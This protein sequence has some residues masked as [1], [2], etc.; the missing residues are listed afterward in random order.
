MLPTTL[1]LVAFSALAPLPL[2][3]APPQGP[4]NSQESRADAERPFL[5]YDYLE[6]GVLKGGQIVVIPGSPLL[7]QVGEL[8]PPTEAPSTTILSNGPP[9]NR[10]DIVLVGDGYRTQD[11]ATYASHCSSLVNN[12][13]LQPPLSN[14]KTF[15]NVHRVDVVSVD[16]GVDNDPTQGVLKNT[17]LDMG[18]WCNGVERALCVNVNK[19]IT[20]AGSAPQRDQVLALANSS[21]Y[22]GVGYPSNNL[23][24]LAAA[25]G[26][27]LEIALHEFGHSFAKLADEYDYGGPTTYG[28]G[29]PTQKNI[30]TLAAAPM[31]S[32]QSKWW[33]W[34]GTGGVSTFE[35]AGYSQFGLFRPTSDSK[36]RN[37]GRPFEEVN[38]EQ[39]VIYF[40]R[41]VDPIDAATPAGVYPPNT[42]LTVDPVDPVSHALSVQWLR[43]GVAIPGATGLT[44]NVASLGLQPGVHAISVSVVDT[45][46][47]VRDEAARAQWMSETREWTID[48]P[49]VVSS[50]C[51]GKLN[52]D[53]CVPS[54]SWSGAP[55]VSSSSPF[56]VRCNDVVAF[57][58][59]LLFYGYAPK[60]A[61]F[62]GGTICVQSPTRRTA[63][64]GSGG[65]PPPDYC[66]GSYSYDFNARIQAGVDSNLVAG[67]TI[68]GQWWYRDPSASFTVGLSNGISFVIGN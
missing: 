18:F 60:N 54:V 55:S 29:E 2:Q 61:P 42:T 3:A 53:G 52:S 41:T 21:K 24:T 8:G 30:S 12:F 49:G 47:L 20:E 39:F 43:N 4:S 7:E 40:Y 5:Y 67:A 26:A 25:N 35:G 64:Q 14:Y 56:D 17:A 45:T 19:A 62:Q 68:Y 65:F 23:G 46:A 1:P 34:L 59:G 9:T 6:N 13:F 27:A 48:V 58:N 38:I 31:G 33:R 44:L 36:M 28:G 22:G 37:L 51:A 57:K 63:P 50:Y 66:S 10:I 11:L 15:F 16:Q 32:T